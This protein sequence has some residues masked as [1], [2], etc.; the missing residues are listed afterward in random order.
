[1]KVSYIVPV[2]KVES[3]LSQCVKSLLAQTY[4]DFEILLVDDGSPD[5][6]P[7]LCDEWAKKDV[8]IKTLHKTNGGLSD[9][10]NYG[11]SQ[12]QGDYV[13]FVD[14]DDYWEIKTGLEYLV[15][16]LD[17]NR[18]IDVLFFNVFYYDNRTGEKSKWPIY[19]EAEKVM[20][21]SIAISNLVKSGNVPMSAWSK[22]VR[23]SLL[24]NCRIEFQRGIY[25]EDT[26][27]F[28][29]LMEYAKDI[30][31]CNEYIYGY[32]QNVSSSITKS[33][34][35]KHANDMRYIIDSEINRI[36]QRN[37]DDCWKESM[38]S[39]LAYN[40]CILL[41][42]FDCVEGKKRRDLWTFL[43][44]YSYLL[45]FKKHPKVNKVRTLKKILG[46]RMTAFI[47]KYYL[48]HR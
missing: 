47:L 22:V 29:S 36:D 23:R 28:I 18:T 6:C 42:Q 37:V 24:V 35:P 32:R 4:N 19:L 33:N 10:R 38:S 2:Y 26:P 31:F 16:I 20:D 34:R 17:H 12:A 46:L 45:K 25:G 40:Y 9:A 41:S 48:K 14:S 27:W 13:I 11:L 8:R 30:A 3:Y 21:T 1:M 43:Q 7:A 39:F 15:E 5:G 44:R